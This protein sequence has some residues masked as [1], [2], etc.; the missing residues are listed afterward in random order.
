MPGI[1]PASGFPEENLR[2]YFFF[3]LP[4]F[5]FIFVFSFDLDLV[6]ELLF[7][8]TG[9]DTSLTVLL[10]DK[11]PKPP[12]RALM[13][14]PSRWIIETCYSQSKQNEDHL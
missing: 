10:P 13:A 5:F 6:A 2:H 12:G 7:F 1:W 8:L 3:F 4:A 14:S 11:H 9:I